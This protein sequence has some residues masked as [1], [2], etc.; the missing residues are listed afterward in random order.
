MKAVIIGARA[1]GRVAVDLLL[2]SIDRT[3]FNA[4]ELVDDNPERWGTQLN[5]V[6][7]C[8]PVA[9][10]KDEDKNKFSA[11]I[12]LGNPLIRRKLALALGPAG[13]Q[14]FNLVH[15]SAYIAP[16][17]QLGVGNTICANAVVNSNAIL[18]NHILVNTSAV[19][20]HDSILADFVT[21]GPACSV[22]GRVELGSGSFIGSNSTILARVKI[23]EGSVVAAGSIVT[24]DVPANTLVMGAPARVKY[25]ID[26]N[27]DWTRLL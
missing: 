15:R 6:D 5:K 1:Q 25:Q 2:S 14:F 4:I 26:A 16:S 21:V 12:A 22:G 24:K 11:L 3:S 18:A 9:K 19:V 7:V 20:E 10:L 13:I 17:A 8:G 27:Y 23:G